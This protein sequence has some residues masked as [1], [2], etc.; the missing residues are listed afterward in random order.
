MPIY[1]YRCEACG[2]TYDLQQS[3]SAATTHTC[4]RCGEGTA[5]RRLHPP[6]VVFKG[7]GFYATDSRKSTTATS[8]SP[9]SSSSSSSASSS[10]S[11]D[12]GASSTSGSAAEAAS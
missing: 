12:S 11:S 6:V 7:S 3:F 1:E 2:A 10:A 8:D 9:P 4:E 5:K